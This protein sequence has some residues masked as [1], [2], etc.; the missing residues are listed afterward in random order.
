MYAIFVSLSGIAFIPETLDSRA[1]YERQK[2]QQS[3]SRPFYQLRRRQYD[4]LKTRQP[5][6][7]AE[8]SSQ[9]LVLL[10]AS[11]CRLCCLTFTVSP[12]TGRIYLL[13]F[14]YLQ[15]AGESSIFSQNKNS[16]LPSATR[17]R[18]RAPFYE[19][20]S[21]IPSSSSRR[22]CRRFSSLRIFLAFSAICP[23]P[24]T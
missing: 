14:S 1:Q 7:L 24:F 12:L 19:L 13:L 4:R 23:D 10:S 18:A 3:Y 16:P 6:R 17:A 21:I 5:S 22:F 15:R 2:C 11:V 9:S 8:F 20:T